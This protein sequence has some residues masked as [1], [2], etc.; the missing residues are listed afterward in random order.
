MTSFGCRLPIALIATLAAAGCGSPPPSP[1]PAATTAA[2]SESAAAKAPAAPTTSAA[3][4]APTAPATSP[5]SVPTA[6]PTVAERVTA[7]RKEFDE[8]SKVFNEKY[9]AAKSDEERNQV[10]Q[11]DYPRPETYAPRF[12]ELAAQAKR[13]PAALDCYLWVLQRVQEAEARDPVYAALAADHVESPKLADAV[14]GLGRYS[15]SLGAE[16]FLRTAIEKSPHREVQGLAT[17]ALAGVLLGMAELS[18]A[19][20]TPR[21]TEEAAN[22]SAAYYGKATLDDLA[23]R[24]AGELR[25]EAEDLLEDVAKHYKDLKTYAPLGVLAEG[26]LFEIRN[27]KIGQVAPDIQGVDVDDV[28]FKLSDYRGKVVVLDFWGFW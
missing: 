24:D 5:E 16:S 13:D 22:S 8:A 25:K 2:A 19:M 20:A 11:N 28:S 27:L 9:Q 17:Y 7:L 4:A 12:L 23:T 1:P 26:D 21:W 15:V 14:R 3:P 18:E 10:F 6:S